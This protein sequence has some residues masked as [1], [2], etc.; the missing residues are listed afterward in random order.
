[1]KRFL[2]IGLLALGAMLGDQAPAS[3]WVNFKFSAGINWQW[4]SAGNNFLWGLWRNG[5]P[6]GPEAFGAHEHGQSHFH[7]Y[8]APQQPYYGFR[9]TMPQ[10][11]QAPAAGAPA[12][13]PTSLPGGPQPATTPGYSNHHGQFYYYQP[14][15]FH[16][17]ADLQLYR[18]GVNFGQ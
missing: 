9:P 2:S 3:A 17:A 8:A 13:A 12:T 4:Q 7:G 5:Q 10:Q 11:Q 14:T 16:P 15:N 6:P 18:F 1:M